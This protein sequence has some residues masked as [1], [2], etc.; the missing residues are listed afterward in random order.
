[1]K[2]DRNNYEPF[3]IDYLEGKL[4]ADDCEMVRIFL[5]ENPDIAEEFESIFSAEIPAEPVIFEGKDALK[6]K[7]EELLPETYSGMDEFLVAKL[8][9]DLSME[10]NALSDKILN[11]SEEAATEYQFLLNTR[12]SP[13]KKLYY[14]DKSSLKRSV[15]PFL[16]QR[17]FRMTL[18]WSAAAMLIAS[19]LLINS[20]LY[21]QEDEPIAFQSQKKSEKIENQM[22]NSQDNVLNELHPETSVAM[23]S[24]GHQQA[25][26]SVKKEFEKAEIVNTVIAVGD[27]IPDQIAYNEELSGYQVA[28]RIE[29]EE[30]E[31]A[32]QPLYSVDQY[33]LKQF[34]KQILKETREQYETRKFSGWDVADAAMQKIGQLFGR[35]WHLVKEYND[36][37]KI[38]NLAFQGRIVYINIPVTK[39]ER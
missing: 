35:E 29:Y 17:Q 24:L 27:S 8:E 22:D 28:I 15:F 6:K 33:L 34:R 18:S 2:I 26:K 21:R 25:E 23:A 7:A 38:T 36:E 37:G 10:E 9:G 30:P 3:L 12:I 39:N 11:I 4:G 31:N 14:P 5:M 13:D 20:R 16:T 32:V 19:F 1:M